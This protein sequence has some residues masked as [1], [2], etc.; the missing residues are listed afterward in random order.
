MQGLVSSPLWTMFVLVLF[1]CLLR[2]GIGHPRDLEIRGVVKGRGGGPSGINP[3]QVMHLTSKEILSPALHRSVKL[4]FV[5]KHAIMILGGLR[6]LD[7]P[8]ARQSSRGCCKSAAPVP[9][10][11]AHAGFHLST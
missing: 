8:L 7:Q 9:R 4:I 3:V 6:K 1:V 11:K 5:A 2:L 10:S